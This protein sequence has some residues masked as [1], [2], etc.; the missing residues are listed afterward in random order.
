MQMGHL[1]D[2]LVKSKLLRP[3]FL[4]HF[5]FGGDN[6]VTKVIYCNFAYIRPV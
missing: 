1:T 2:A 5:A 6:A 4:K 3:S